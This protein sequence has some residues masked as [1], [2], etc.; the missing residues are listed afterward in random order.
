MRR[1]AD[2]D[3]ELAEAAIAQQPADPR[4]SARLLDARDLSDHRF[5]DL[6]SL[7]RPGD[8]VVVN[9]T[10]VRKAR[11][12]GHK[13]GTGGAVEA[14]LLSRRGDA[15][16][17]TLL[18]P[19]RRLRP[20]TE[21]VFGPVTATVV[22]TPVG[23]TALVDFDVDGDLDAVL[24]EIGEMPL[25]PYIR[26][27]Q[28]RP[29]RYQTIF[30]ASPG[31]AAAPTAGL[32]FTPEVLA[33]LARRGVAVAKVDLEVGLA[34]FRPL[35]GERVEDHRMHAEGFTVPEET[36]ELV[37]E[38]T[39]AG[40]R[41]VAIGTTVTRAL[42]TVA[43]GPGRILPGRG[44]TRLFLRPGVPF[45]V[46][47][48]LVTNFHLPRSSLLVLL[49]AFMGEGWRDVYETALQRGYRFLSFGDAMICAREA[50]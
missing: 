26:S 25:P 28:G 49:A 32:H 7:L 15:R 43:V 40:G 12:R 24:E 23:G 17:E 8:L 47:D 46:V 13:R 10:K 44:E 50:R 42:E 41:V 2:F 27:W 31:S 30:A 34:T 22:S 36:A 6:P 14:L 19:A 21:L 35:T 37:A 48:L 16:W 1:V 9:E 45:Q 18:R 20:G 33:E 5:A 39:A 11:L 3:Y 29:D 38:T 4:D